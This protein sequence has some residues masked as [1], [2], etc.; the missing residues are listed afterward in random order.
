VV[1]RAISRVQRLA[2]ADCDNRVS[3]ARVDEAAPVA[4]LLTYSAE[5]RSAVR[6]EFQRIIAVMLP[7]DGDPVEMTE[8]QSWLQLADADRSLPPGDVWRSLFAHWVPKRQRKAESVATAAMHREIACV[9]EEHR[10]RI[11]RKAADLKDWL[12]G[13]ADDLCGRYEP[14][15]GDLFG[16]VAD[17]PDWQSRSA[18]LDRLA[19]FAADGN[20]PP[21][22]RREA[23]SAV[24]LFQRRSAEHAAHAALSPPAL[25]PVGMLMLV[26]SA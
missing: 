3:V 11:K 24:E 18:P 4:V 13:R 1:R 20:N 19:A 25:R 9:L 16:A 21:A 22:R 2:R 5:Q 6:I 12:R 23:S 10:Q 15:T 14:G 8:P 26:P 17:R 7:L